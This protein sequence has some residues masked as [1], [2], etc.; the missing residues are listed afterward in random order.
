LNSKFKFE[1]FKGVIFFEFSEFWSNLINVGY[2]GKQPSVML[3]EKVS[4]YFFE[5]LVE[6]LEKDTEN[7]IHEKFLEKSRLNLAQKMV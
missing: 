6:K 3:F 4:K 1:K 7:V 2:F 5:L